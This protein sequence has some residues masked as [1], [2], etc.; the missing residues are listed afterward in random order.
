VQQCLGDVIGI[1]DAAFSQNWD[2]P[3]ERRL[4]RKF[5]P[6]VVEPA[7]EAAAIPSRRAGITL[8]RIGQ[9]LLNDGKF[10]DS[11]RLNERGFGIQFN[12]FG[13]EHPFT[14]ATMNNLA[15]TY[16]EQGNL[17]DAVDLQ[18]RNLEAGKSTLGEE[19]SDTLTSMN[20][21]ALTYMR[22][23]KLTGCSRSAG[24]SAGAKNE[25]AGRRA[26][27][28]I[29]KHDQLG[30]DLSGTEEVASRSGSTGEECEGK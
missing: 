27:K 2:T 14:L 15:S 28:Y 20:N 19:H 16:L 21:L 4:C 9:F 1:C 6:Q 29:E 25:N 17:H 24:D 23:G 8:H 13:K 10:K 12:L 7:F 5:Q 11:E 22:Q 18:E 26:S 30:S 3:E